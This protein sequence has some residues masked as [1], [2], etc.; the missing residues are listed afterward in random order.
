MNILWVGAHQDDEMKVMGTLLKYRRQGGH[1]F[2]FVCATNGDKGMSFRRSPA[3]QE[4]LLGTIATPAPDSRAAIT[5]LHTSRRARLL[6]SMTMPCSPASLI[7]SSIRLASRAI[8][9]ESKTSPALVCI[10]PFLTP[11]TNHI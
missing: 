3:E 9:A 11:W 1:R 8:A 4:K 5:R 7:T 6:S 10:R 2:A